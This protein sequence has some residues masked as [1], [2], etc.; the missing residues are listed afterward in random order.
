MPIKPMMALAF[1]VRVGLLGGGGGNR[2]TCDPYK[3]FATDNTL[4]PDV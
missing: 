2:L 1:Q 4:F 3:K